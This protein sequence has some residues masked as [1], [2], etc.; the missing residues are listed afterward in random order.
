MSTRKLFLTIVAVLLLTSA[1][2]GVDSWTTYAQGPDGKGNPSGGQ[3][4]M[5][6]GMGMMSH[7]GMMGGQR[8][9]GMM[10]PRNNQGDLMGPGM[11]NGSS[12]QQGWM[13]QSGDLYMGDYGM[14]TGW[15]PPAD[16]APAGA[17]LSLD[18]A[19]A[20]AEAYI[21]SQNDP[22]LVLGE[23]IQFSDHFYANAVETDSGHAAFEFLIDPAS[24]TVYPSPGPNMMWDLR[25]GMH[26]GLGVNMMEMSGVPAGADG[27]ELTIS[28]EQAQVAAQ[29]AVD[30]WQPGLTVASEPATFYGYYT[31]KV[32]DGETVVDLAHVNGYSGEVYT[33]ES[34][35]HQGFAGCMSCHPGQ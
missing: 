17:T 32:L 25:Y 23:V 12:G 22:N 21:A 14:M 13:G 19:T 29:Q 15:T 26:S 10:G 11:M 5:G 27:V 30:E 3:P 35:R 9:S 33:G 18:E 2:V 16:L 20:V 31:F 6:P 7:Q 4:P 34:W 28:P 8:Q 24:G 1:V